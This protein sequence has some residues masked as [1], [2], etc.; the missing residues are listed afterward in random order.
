MQEKTSF[1]TILPIVSFSCYT[2]LAS[3]VKLTEHGNLKFAI[4]PFNLELSTEATT[5]HSNRKNPEHNSQMI[6]LDSPS[7]PFNFEADNIKKLCE[8]DESPKIKPRL[9]DTQVKVAIEPIKI[10]IKHKNSNL[11]RLRLKFKRSM[12]GTMTKDLNET[13]PQIKDELACVRPMISNLNN[14]RQN[15]YKTQLNSAYRQNE[16][17]DSICPSDI[18]NIKPDTETG[19]LFKVSDM[20]CTPRKTAYFGK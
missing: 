3:K 8:K 5:S 20:F 9:N 7:D 11:N 18:D 2:F 17:M 19:C 1:Y 14:C 15:N 6:D 4:R 12:P 16:K 10:K 13:C